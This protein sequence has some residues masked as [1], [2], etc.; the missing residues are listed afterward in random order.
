[1]DDSH[2]FVGG[3]IIPNKMFSL[4]LHFG[5]YLA[6]NVVQ[7][8][9]DPPRAIKTLAQSEAFRLLPF[10]DYPLIPVVIG[11]QSVSQELPSPDLFGCHRSPP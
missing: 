10:P 6:L 4:D 7:G 8:V 5:Q 9:N 3:F 1:M 2:S 11:F